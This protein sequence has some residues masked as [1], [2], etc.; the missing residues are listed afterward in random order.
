MH[1]RRDPSPA[2]QRGISLIGLLFWAVVVGILA[3]VALRVIPTVNEY[4][5]I[6]RAV[7]KVATEGGTTPA[8]IRAS[9]ER[10]KD[11]E[12]S[13]T[14]ITSKD[15]DITKENDKV[16]IRFAYDKQ[17]ELMDPVYLLIKYRGRSR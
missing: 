11:I 12:Y 14:S 15:L 17:I 2:G 10:Q 5:T 13:I 9:F 3:L 7:N 4:L 8:E 6:Q 1:E 16:V